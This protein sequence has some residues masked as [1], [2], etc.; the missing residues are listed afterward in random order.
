MI[1][2]LEAAI[3]NALPDHCDSPECSCPTR[4]EIAEIAMRVVQEFA[5]GQLT[6]SEMPR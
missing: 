1:V 3:A 4:E 5:V 6:M 2:G